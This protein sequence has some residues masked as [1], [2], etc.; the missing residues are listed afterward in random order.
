MAIISKNAV[1][2]S[3]I[4]TESPI[5][6]ALLGN[7][8][9]GVKNFMQDASDEDALHKIPYYEKMGYTKKQLIKMTLKNLL[10]VARRWAV[11]RINKGEDFAA[12]EDE[13]MEIDSIEVKLYAKMNATFL[14]SVHIHGCDHKD[15]G[16]VEELEAI[17][18][19]DQNVYN[20]L[21]GRMRKSY[22][23]EKIRSLEY[24]ISKTT[25]YV[26]KIHDVGRS[27][28]AMLEDG[29]Q[30]DFETWSAEQALQ[31]RVF[32]ENK[33]FLKQTIKHLESMQSNKVKLGVSEIRLLLN[34]KDGCRREK[35][36]H[37]AEEW[38]ISIYNSLP[39]ATAE[40]KAAQGQIYK[41][42]CAFVYDIVPLTGRISVNMINF[43]F[44]R[45]FLSPMSRSL[46]LKIQPRINS[47]S[48]TPLFH[49]PLQRMLKNVYADYLDGVFTASDYCVV[50]VALAYEPELV[51]S[52]LKKA[53]ESYE[54]G[55]EFAM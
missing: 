54:P 34:Q 1:S 28:F 55:N 31:D 47:L 3:S 21:L 48:M 45:G 42:I 16:F 6:K 5:A 26:R 33:L 46:L 49:Y 19:F 18:G 14:Q 35:L 25:E 40:E 20:K 51:R 50:Q 8:I 30:P 22:A 9:N 29:K 11:D 12:F 15:I 27:A 44:D 39:S 52:V 4:V 37:L 43:I 38:I 2:E 36:Y 23:K 7:L 32:E 13:I 10:P 53:Y 24:L 17:E 41:E